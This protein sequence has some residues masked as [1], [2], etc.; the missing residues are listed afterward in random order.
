MD[1]KIADILSK[2]ITG[3][4]LTPEDTVYLNIWINKKEQNRKEFEILTGLNFRIKLSELQN[5]KSDIFSQV[6]QRINTRKNR[7]RNLWLTSAAAVS[8][9]IAFFAGGYTLNNVPPIENNPDDVVFNELIVPAGAKTQLTLS[10]GSKV[11]LNGGSKLIYP[12]NFNAKTRDVQLDGEAYFDIS[13]NKSKPFIVHASSIQIKVLGTAFNV[14]SYS[15]DKTIETTLVRGLV[16]ISGIKNSLNTEPLLIKPNQK[17]TFIKQNGNLSIGSKTNIQ[18]PK[19][20]LKK[21]ISID[22]RQVNTVPII[23]WKDKTLVF[24]NATF[25]EIALKLERWFGVK[26]NLLNDDLKDFKYKGRFNHNETIYQVLEVIK[27][28]TPINYEVKNYEIY[29]NLN[30]RN[31]IN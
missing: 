20:N 25:E 19:E 21:I 30:K 11:W 17:A 23:S 1:N 9:I 12:S 14:K 22:V 7:I 24:E 29:I 6:S 27:V 5:S 28:T 8:I 31:T 16:E 10:D 13:E 18:A 3:S 4:E 26:I 15:E 2:C